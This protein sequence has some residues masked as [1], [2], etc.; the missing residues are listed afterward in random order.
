MAGGEGRR[1]GCAGLAFFGMALVDFAPDMA[2][3]LFGAEEVF[4]GGEC[5]EALLGGEFD[6]DADAVGVLTGEGDEGLGG[7]GNGFEMDVASEMVLLAQFACDI[8]DEFHGVVG[9]ADDAA[10]EEEAFDVVALVEVEGELDDFV[11]G[12][13]GAGDVA[14]AAVDAVV[15]VVEAGIGH[16]D[17]EE[18]DAATVGGVGMADAGAAGG[19][20]AL[21]AARV[22]PGG[23][24]A[25][26]GRV[27]FGGVGEDFEFAGEVHELLRRIRLWGRWE[28]GEDGGRVVKFGLAECFWWEM[29]R[30][31]DQRFGTLSDV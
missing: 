11:G 15:A 25:G 10:A 30:A 23:A 13:A 28:R 20:N 8:D 9:A 6:V 4:F 19:A 18:G 7:F 16:E 26:A 22:F 17:L 5:V 21:A 14:G 24:A 2:H 31:W 29:V 27:V 3:G 1:F 12:E